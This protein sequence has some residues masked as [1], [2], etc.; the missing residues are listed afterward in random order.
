MTD[1]YLGWWN[2]F[3]LILAIFNS[4]AVPV[5]MTVYPELTGHSWY[6]ISDVIINILFIIDILVQFNTSI[7]N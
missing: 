2:N 5:E 1:M 4:F 7:Y 6:F 3:V